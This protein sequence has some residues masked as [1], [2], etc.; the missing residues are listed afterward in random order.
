VVDLTKEGWQRMLSCG[1]WGISNRDTSMM[2]SSTRDIPTS[3]DQPLA[4]AFRPNR[5]LGQAVL[6]QSA[7]RLSQNWEWGC[8]A[9]RR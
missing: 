5:L 6:F 9:R 1:S 7:L 2:A 4:C 8:H 3:A